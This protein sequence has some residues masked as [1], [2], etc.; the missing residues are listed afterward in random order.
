MYEADFDIFNQSGRNKAS[1]MGQNSSDTY[2]FKMEAAGI[3]HFASQ[4]V[5]FYSSPQL[6][7]SFI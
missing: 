1:G 6:L 3:E 5:L 7:I 4:A 2:N